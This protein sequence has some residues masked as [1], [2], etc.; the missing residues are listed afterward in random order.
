VYYPERLPRLPSPRTSYLGGGAA[1]KR[2]RPP[3]SLEGVDRHGAVIIRPAKLERVT[4]PAGASLRVF[5]PRAEA[6]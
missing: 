2:P 6:S 5:L 1:G 4:Q 3:A